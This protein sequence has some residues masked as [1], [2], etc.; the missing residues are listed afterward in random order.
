M[1]KICGRCSTECVHKAVAVSPWTEAE[2]R[3]LSDAIERF[4]IGNW[5]LVRGEVPGRT[6]KDCFVRFHSVNFNGQAD[7]YDVLLAT[8]RKMLPQRLSE[9]KAASL[10]MSRSKLA[11]SDFQLQLKEVQVC[12]QTL[13]QHYAISSGDPEL[14][15]HQTFTRINRRRR[16][17]MA[18]QINDLPRARVARK[19]RGIAVQGSTPGGAEN[20]G[21]SSERYVRRRQ[22]RKGL[23][24][25]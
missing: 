11:A 25:A 10:G 12:S 14:D 13:G 18:L 22:I 9:M 3:A 17:S 4:G 21:A 6:S 20:A 24:M 5:N 8:R 7:M 1:Y 15:Q 2:D 16:I 23:E 19:R